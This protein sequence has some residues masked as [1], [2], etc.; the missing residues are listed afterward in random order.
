MIDWDNLFYI[1]CVK[2]GR[3]DKEFWFES[4]PAKTFTL[5]DKYIQELNIQNGNTDGFEN[6]IETTIDNIPFF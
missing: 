1:Y 3:K 5:I 6:N 2:L 4:T